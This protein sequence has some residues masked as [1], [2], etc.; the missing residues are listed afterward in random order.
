MVLAVVAI[1]FACLFV[2]AIFR[3]GTCISAIIV[4]YGFE[5]WAMANSAFFAQQAQLV[6]FLVGG[7]VL[8]AF[9]ASIAHH[10]NPF[11]INTAAFWGF[12]L[13]YIYSG[14]SCLWAPKV[15]ETSVF[16]YQ[17]YMPYT[18]CFGVMAP[19]CIR[20]KDD[21]RAAL[22]ATLILGGVTMILLLA[23]TE[24]HSWG[25][26]IVVAEGSTMQ[27]RVGKSTDRMAPLA[28]AELAA[29]VGLITMLMNYRG[30]TR[31]FAL[32][33]WPILLMA[34]ALI[35]RSGSRGQLLAC[36]GAGGACIGLARGYKKELQVFVG[37][38]FVIL[39]GLAAIVM[40]AM[41]STTGEERWTASGM[42]EDF[43]GTRGHFCATLLLAWINA[44]PTAWLIGLGSSAS[45]DVL[46][47][48]PHVVMVEVLAELGFI[49]LGLY[50]G[51]LTLIGIAIYQAIK[52]AFKEPEDRGMLAAVIALFLLTFL[53]TF[54]QGSFQMQSTFFMIC[55]MLARFSAILVQEHAKV[56]RMRSLYMNQFYQWQNT[57]TAWLPTRDAT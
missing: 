57:A 46:Q 48:Y 52:V 51:W 3:P 6:N 9:I 30:A 24:I 4:G 23:G 17:Y 45:F 1:V 12:L 16:V 29:S 22:I 14:L 38:T 13:L 7:V 27:N 32:L 8:V 10:G 36:V 20:T 37:A 18:L 19:F 34:F 47:I 49:G 33:R 31:V 53:L 11:A 54:K 2:A 5:Q 40:F 25:R 15:M 42:A 43:E 35:L 21:M 39:T 56:E 26:T 55:M 44:G 41:F 50:L 28:V